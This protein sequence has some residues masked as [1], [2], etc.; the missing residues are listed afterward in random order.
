MK[1]INQC[2]EN[3]IRNVDKIMIHIPIKIRIEAYKAAKM[4]IEKKE[5]RYICT[6]LQK[7]LIDTTGVRLPIKE[8]DFVFPELKKRLPI[9]GDNRIKVLELCIQEVRSIKNENK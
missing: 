2:V 9:L 6:G 5:K 1:L 4:M 3:V 8:I 7:Y